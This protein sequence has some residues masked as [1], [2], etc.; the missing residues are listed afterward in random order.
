MFGTCLMSVE[1]RAALASE[2]LFGACVMYCAV[3]L[4]ASCSFVRVTC[5]ISWSCL[6]LRLLQ[7]SARPFQ[8]AD[9]SKF[10]AEDS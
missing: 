6:R 7:P 5:V 4:I 9:F 3:L 8:G 10:W 1:V 2:F